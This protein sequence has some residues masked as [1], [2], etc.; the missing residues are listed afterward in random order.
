MNS[1]QKKNLIF[2]I[3]AGI[4][5]I[6]IGITSWIFFNHYRFNQYTNDQHNFSIK[7]PASWTLGENINNAAVIFYS[8]QETELDI[9]RENV[10]IVVQ[11][12]SKNPLSLKRY[13][14][15]AIRQMEAVFSNNMMILESEPMFFA[16]QEGYKFVFTGKTPE[17]ELQYMSVWTITGLTAYQV[18]YTALASQ[19]DRH[20]PKVKRMIR[21][22]H[23]N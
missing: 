22:F 2:N 12:I 20:L 6:A 17:T 8:P 7:Y 3:A 21:S 13:S 1:R 16:G 11:D 5:I 23:L 10:N 14:K 19:Y 18:T 15:T 9:F 4:G